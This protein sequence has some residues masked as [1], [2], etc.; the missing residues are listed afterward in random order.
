MTG[1]GAPKRT[2]T[3]KLKNQN[4][5]S[6]RQYDEQLMP[7]RTK[8]QVE[9]SG[10]SPAPLRQ[11]NQTQTHDDQLAGDESHQWTEALVHEAIGIRPTAGFGR[12][13]AVFIAGAVVAGIVL[14]QTGFGNVRARQS[15]GRWTADVCWG[16]VSPDEQPLLRPR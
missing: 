10:S 4:G 5:Y 16:Q 14:Y 8:A 7:V 6:Y 12:C 3:A 13:R 9:N 15:C 2:V 11:R 1:L